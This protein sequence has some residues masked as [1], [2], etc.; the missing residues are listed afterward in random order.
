M[1]HNNGS[2]APRVL[3]YVRINGNF[4]WSKNQ[5]CWPFVQHKR[6][7]NNKTKVSRFASI[8][9]AYLGGEDGRIG[10]DERRFRPDFRHS[11]GSDGILMKQKKKKCV[12]RGGGGKV[13]TD[14]KASLGY[15]FG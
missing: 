9:A 3:E 15:S 4:L 7:K 14:K 10:Q 6:A 11:E 5:I 8:L 13:L 1:K 12:A 2:I